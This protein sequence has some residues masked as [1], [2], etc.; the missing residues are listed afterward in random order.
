[1]EWMGGW[2]DAI[3]V[4]TVLLGKAVPGGVEVLVRKKSEF[5]FSCKAGRL[6]AEKG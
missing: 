1:M 2:E 4:S 3:N 6:G 5:I